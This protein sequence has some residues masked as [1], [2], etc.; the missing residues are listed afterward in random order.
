MLKRI[1]DVEPVAAVRD[2]DR[3]PVGRED[4]ESPITVTIG[5]IVRYVQTRLSKVFQPIGD[6]VTILQVRK[7]SQVARAIAA[8][9][10]AEQ[11]LTDIGKMSALS[12]TTRSTL[13]AAIN[14][15]NRKSGLTAVRDA[16]TNIKASDDINEAT[17]AY[18]VELESHLASLES[19]YQEI[20]DVADPP[21]VA[22]DPEL[23]VPEGGGDTGEDAPPSDVTEDVEP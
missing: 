17:L 14:E 5:Q 8:A 4:N 20:S 6:Y 16:I 1:K 22:D 7:D 23:A 15:V 12:T 13:V 21:E 18:V 11:A 10:K 19:R 2:D 9:D 3:M